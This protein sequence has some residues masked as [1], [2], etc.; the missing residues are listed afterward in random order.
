MKLTAI[1]LIL[2]GVVAAGAAAVLIAVY[3]F[4]PPKEVIVEVPQEQERVEIL[5]AA[6][7]L[8]QHVIVDGDAVARE[9]VLR[10]EVPE[11]SIR[12]IT[13]VVGRPLAKSMVKG[14]PFMTTDFMKEEHIV[15]IRFGIKLSLDIN[16]FLALF[17]MVMARKLGKR[18]FLFGSLKK[19]LNGL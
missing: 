5:V 7:A 6:R 17:A 1:C 9:F 8:D 19:M 2:L 4:A 3:P 12:V 11:T 18:A 14:E 10:E 15:Q 16:L 13:D